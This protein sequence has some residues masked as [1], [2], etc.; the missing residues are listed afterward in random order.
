MSTNRFGWTVPAALILAV[1][2]CLGGW[3]LF[4][5]VRAQDR[6]TPIP[7]Q[8]GGDKPTRQPVGPLMLAKLSNA[9]RV[10]EGL[11]THDFDR[12]ATAASAMKIMSLDPP[13][14]WEKKSSDDEVYDHFRMEFMRQAARLEKMAQEKNLSGAAWYQQNLTATCI[15][16]H[17]YIRDYSEEK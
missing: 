13:A 5:G 2:I 7:V 16:C 8:S 1:L 10:V 17:E 14:G 12:I 4:T 3:S 9:Q 15:A 6:V 11:V